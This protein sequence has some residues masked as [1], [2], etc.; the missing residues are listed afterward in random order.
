MSQEFFQVILTEGK[1]GIFILQPDD[2]KFTSL[3]SCQAGDAYRF[4]RR[5]TAVLCVCVCACVYV[6]RKNEHY[7]F[8]DITDLTHGNALKDGASRLALLFNFRRTTLDD[9][10]NNVEREREC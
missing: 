4:Y 6:L 2:N 8:C 7:L 10:R 1:Q 3:H 5:L 9:Y